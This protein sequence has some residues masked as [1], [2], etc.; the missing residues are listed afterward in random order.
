VDGA[1]DLTVFVD[2]AHTPD[3]LEKV[4]RTLRPLAPTRIITVFG[5]GGDRDRGKRPLMGSIAARLSDLAILTSDNPRSENPRDILREIEEGV[6]GE[7]LPQLL[8][9]AELTSKERGYMELDDRAEAIS[10]AVQHARPGDT[11]L[12]AGKGHEDYQLIGAERRAF[13]DREE[14]RKALEKR[15]HGG[16]G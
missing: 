10:L 13:D 1:S 5:C 7:G 8:Q 6:R 16:T 11:L 3:A 9:L 2:Y 15:A 12:I 14:A 4:I